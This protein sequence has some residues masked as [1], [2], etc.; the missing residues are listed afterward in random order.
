MLATATVDQKH[1]SDDD[2]IRDVSAVSFGMP[3]TATVD[4][5]HRDD[6]DTGR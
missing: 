2:T 6:D 4:Q 1:R 5:K 3:A